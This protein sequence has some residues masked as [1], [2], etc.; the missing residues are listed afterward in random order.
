MKIIPYMRFFWATAMSF[1]Y[2]RQTKLDIQATDD[3]GLFFMLLNGLLTFSFVSYCI[4]IGLQEI[5][6]RQPIDS[7]YF[8]S[9]GL[10][11][12]ILIFAGG[13]YLLVGL[14]RQQS[15]FWRIGIMS[16]WQLGLL[17]LL[18]VDI[19]RIRVS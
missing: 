6:H 17:M 2:I 3:M 13:L 11:F 12:E 16:L 8:E 14:V 7:K 15:D 5:K 9:F 1:N 4:V 10:I 18:T 19:K